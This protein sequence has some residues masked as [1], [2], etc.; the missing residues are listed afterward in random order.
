MKNQLFA[1]PIMF[2]VFY[3]SSCKKESSTALSQYTDAV[4]CNETDDNLNTYS[5]KI[6]T[7]LNN[8]CATA[9]C[10]DAVT[11]ESGKDYSSFAGAKA[12]MDATG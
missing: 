9:G 4:T 10:H 8:S 11:H 5:Q 6:S 2:A 7:I 3:A 12:G 1:A